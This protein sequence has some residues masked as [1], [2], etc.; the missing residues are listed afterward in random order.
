VQNYITS[1]D[2]TK[3]CQVS[4]LPSTTASV[5]TAKAE[6]ELPSHIFVY[7]QVQW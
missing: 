7:R 1:K 3:R 6:G 2:V 4:S 5:E